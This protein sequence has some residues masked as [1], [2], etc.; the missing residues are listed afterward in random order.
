MGRHAAKT[1]IGPPRAAKSSQPRKLSRIRRFR[2]LLLLVCGLVAAQSSLA[3]AQTSTVALNP[4]QGAPGTTVTG[5]GANW[6]AGDHMQVSWADTGAVL[7]NT[8]VSSS[9]SFSVKFTVPAGAATGVHNVYF[10]D[11]DSR[12]F[13]VPTF[14]VSNR[15]PPPVASS[16]SDLTPTPITVNGASYGRTP[17]PVGQVIHFDS[18]VSNLGGTGTGVFNI[19]W[20]VDGQNVKPAAY[21]SHAGVPAHSTVLNGNSQFDWTPTTAGTSTITFVVDSDNFVKESN[22]SNNSAS[23]RVVVAPPSC[24]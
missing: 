14:T 20:L 21:G 1:L 9:N 18:G 5:N 4:Q 11:L 23:V 16:P 6:T 2:L 22:E 8:T 10:T 24:R 7:A 17:L 3:A 12:Y 19:R 13:L 15:Q